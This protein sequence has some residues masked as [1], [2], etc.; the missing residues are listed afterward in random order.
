MTP[1]EGLSE[2]PTGIDPEAIEND[3]LSPLIEGV[4]EN[5][6]FFDRT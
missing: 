6:S 1:F 4:T 3:R 5:D 2:S